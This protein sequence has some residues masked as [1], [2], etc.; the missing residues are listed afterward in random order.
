MAAR[1][2]FR[3][4][5][6]LPYVMP[7]VATSTEWLW[8]YQPQVGILDRLL[9]LFGLPSNIAWVSDPDT[10]LWA[11]IIFTM[12]L[13]LG[14]PPPGSGTTDEHADRPLPSGRPWTAP[15]GGERFGG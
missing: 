10:A 9:G 12:W 15:P 2:P 13:P 6:F 5:Y 1:G 8:I 14:S 3:T 4:L 11:V 7:V